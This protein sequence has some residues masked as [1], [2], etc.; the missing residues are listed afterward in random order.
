[1]QASSPGVLA[2]TSSLSVRNCLAGRERND[3]LPCSFGSLDNDSSG[4]LDDQAEPAILMGCAG[5]V[6]RSFSNPPRRNSCRAAFR[7]PWGLR[8]DHLLALSGLG[9][10]VV[11][12]RSV[13]QAAETRSVPRQWKSRYL[14]YFDG[15]EDRRRARGRSASAG[16]DA[17]IGSTT[18]SAPPRP[19]S[20]AAPRRSFPMS[21]CRRRW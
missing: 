3:D 1:M 17:L 18:A 10:H 5:L 20:A 6:L 2:R 16:V 15:D 19:C 14:R 9:G 7:R 8:N 13:P 4:N 21:C 11:G 12:S